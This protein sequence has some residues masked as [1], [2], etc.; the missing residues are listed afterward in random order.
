MLKLTTPAFYKK[1]S[2]VFG[3]C[4]E[5][6]RGPL[7]TRGI[8]RGCLNDLPKIINTCHY[9]G[10][11]LNQHDICGSCIKQ[12]PRIDRTVC[13][14]HYTYPVDKLIKNIKYKQKLTAL[15]PLVCRLTERIEDAGINNIDLLIP[16]PMPTA[17][18]MARGM[19]QA[20][21]IA[22]IIS[23]LLDIPTNPYALQ[24]TRRTLPMHMLDTKQR[25]QNVYG[26]FVWDSFSQPESVAIVDDIITSGATCDEISRCLKASGIRRVEAWALARAS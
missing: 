25:K 2:Q 22:K 19:N 15:Y 23:K 13:A 8:C 18:M 24:R 10:I 20:I 4:C 5:L 16:V 14:Y 21:E 17:R 1:T 9:C 11:P 6:C 7:S 26:A 3:F 12:K